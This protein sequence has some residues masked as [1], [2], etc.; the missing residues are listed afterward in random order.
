M[1]VQSCL[2]H[3]LDKMIV[4]YL[5][6]P[7]ESDFQSPCVSILQ[8]QYSDISDDDIDFPIS[9]KCG[10]SDGKTIQMQGMIMFN[11]YLSV[12]LYF[13]NYN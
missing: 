13:L 5:I 12:P 4:D 3:N 11:M 10:N 9:R 6:L 8:D 7:E 2:L 1:T